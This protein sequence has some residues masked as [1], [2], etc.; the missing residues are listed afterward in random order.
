[1]GADH[2]IFET[3]AL[4]RSLSRTHLPPSFIICLIT[5][6]GRVSGGLPPKAISAASSPSAKTQLKFKMICSERSAAISAGRISMHLLHYVGQSDSDPPPTTTP[7]YYQD[8]TPSSGW[9]QTCLRTHPYYMTS[10]LFLCLVNLINFF[11]S[12]YEG[13]FVT[14]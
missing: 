8:C 13:L 14:T 3:T 10:S 9:R 5:S 11:C 4:S 6:G 12:P 7:S 2:Q 1:M